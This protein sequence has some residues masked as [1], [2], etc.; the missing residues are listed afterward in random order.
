MKFTPLPR[1]A[2]ALALLCLPLLAAAADPAPAHPLVGT[3]SWPLFGGQCTETF[4]YRSNGRL[5]ATSGQAVTEWSYTVSPQAE[6]KG[7]FKVVETSV[8]HNGKADCS[9]DTLDQDGEV[10]TRYIQFNPA[11]NR[12]V[13]CK[14]ESLAACF[15]P[16]DRID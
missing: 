8:R 14:A 2:G 16:L 13:V 15:G 1:L 3:W 9:G 11:R 7:F 4:Q 6:E 5:L 10:A 12:L